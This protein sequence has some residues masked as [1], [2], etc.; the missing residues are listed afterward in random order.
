MTWL[1]PSLLKV[2]VFGERHLLRTLT[3]LSLLQPDADTLGLGKDTPLGRAVHRFR[4]DL[5]CTIA[6]RAYDFRERQ[7]SITGRERPAHR[8]EWLAFCRDRPARRNES[9][10]QHQNGA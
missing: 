5:D 10:G 4:Y 8:F 1:R 3:L 7:L 9:R 2:L 6:T